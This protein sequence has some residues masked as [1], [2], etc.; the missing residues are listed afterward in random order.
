LGPLRVALNRTGMGFMETVESLGRRKIQAIWE[1]LKVFGRGPL[2][3]GIALISMET[4]SDFGGVSIFGLDT[5]TTA[6]YTAWS[7]FFSLKIAARLSLFL[8]LFAFIFLMFKTTI[9]SHV[10]LKDSDRYIR[11]PLWLKWISLIFLS[12]IFFFSFL[13]PVFQLILW[14]FQGFIT[15]WG[16]NYLI[17]LRNTF[18]VGSFAAIITVFLSV[19]LVFQERKGL[20]IILTQ[21]RNLALMGYSL[22]GNIVAVAVFFIGGTTLFSLFG[23]T[24]IGFFF[25]LFALVYRFFSVSYR[26]LKVGAQEINQEIEFSSESLGVEGVYYFFKVFIP[27]LRPSMLYAFLFSFIEI[28]KEM[29]ITLMLRPTGFDTLSTKI[30]ELTSEGEWERASVPGIILLLI[31]IT[32]IYF[33]M[34]RKKYV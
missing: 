10:L 13:L 14:F 12:L 11:L 22:P 34:K 17:L 29:P 21:L 27:L 2:L 6:I 9:K 25:L 19:F 32:S 20:P 24:P 28:I 8:M 16:S 18:S 31:G 26:N 33:L 3:V 5:F 30:Y 4:L 15:E 7:G 23:I 1:L